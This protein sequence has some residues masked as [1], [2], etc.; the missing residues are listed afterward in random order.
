MTA[1]HEND[2]SVP[3]VLSSCSLRGRLVRLQDVSTTIV[4]QHDYPGPV[5]KILAEFLAAGATLAGLLKYEGVFTLQTKTSG[6]LS[7]AVIDM[8]HQGNLRGYAQFKADKITSKDSFKQLF[9]QGYLAFTVDQG[10]KDK[11][12]QGIVTLNHETLPLALE[13]YFEQMIVDSKF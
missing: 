10:I 12:Y 5:A 4:G 8:T 2:I 11:R 9:D 3:F 6:P 1:L 13:H 7:L